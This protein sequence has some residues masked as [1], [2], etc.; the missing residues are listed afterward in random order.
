MKFSSQNYKN[1][2]VEKKIN[3]EIQIWS[4]QEIF[5]AEKLITLITRLHN[6]ALVFDYKREH[7]H[8]I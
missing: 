6:V 2:I 3:I 4:I 1:K 7:L 8:F 5:K